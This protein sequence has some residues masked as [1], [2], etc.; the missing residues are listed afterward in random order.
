MSVSFCARPCIFH[1][2]RKTCLEEGTVKLGNS[3]TFGQDSDAIIRGKMAALT[4]GTVPAMGIR[5]V[6]R[7]Y[8]MCR[9]DF[10]HAGKIDGE[11]SWHRS[12][13]LW[14]LGKS[15]GTLPPGKC[16]RGFKIVLHTTWQFL[17]NIAKIAFY[18]LAI[19][20]FLL[21]SLFAQA[22]P[23]EGR[24]LWAALEHAFSRDHIQNDLYPL[25]DYLAICMQP[26]QVIA[27]R[28]FHKLDSPETYDPYYIQS[29]YRN[30]KYQII[31]NQAFY[32]DELGADKCKE[33]LEL[34]KETKKIE[35]DKTTFDAIYPAIKEVYDQLM[36]VPQERERIIEAQI[37]LRKK[38][39][40]CSIADVTLAMAEIRTTIW[41]DNLKTAQQITHMKK[42]LP[43]QLPSVLHD[44]ILDYWLIPVQEGPVIA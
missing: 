28:H 37:A 36:K 8:L 3:L 5:I 25:S 30:I 41:C 35:M 7:L 22:F 4:I 16:S 27:E 34:I 42:Q 18:P 38:D 14:S 6:Y 43:E 17:K 32:H 24:Y 26:K 15:S 39:P 9:G 29:L 13:Q 12:R 40:K 19:V 23:R 20:G 21:I 2:P 44:L 31:E 1:D 11:K 33:I 10:Y